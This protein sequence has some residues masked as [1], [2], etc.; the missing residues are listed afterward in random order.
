[1][2]CII[3]HRRR[4]GFTVVELLMILAIIATIGSLIA[5]VVYREE[6]EEFGQRIETWFNNSFGFPSYWILIPAIAFYIIFR[7][8]KDS[9]TR[10]SIKG[11]IICLTSYALSL[12]IMEI[13]DLEI[14][15]DEWIFE[16]FALSGT[17]GAI[18][19]LII[20]EISGRKLIAKP[21]ASSALSFLVLSLFS[22]A[23]TSGYGFTLVLYHLPI[24]LIG[25]ATKLGK[26][27]Q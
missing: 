15:P 11:M 19:I 18:S 16:N 14:L 8:N 23:I 22:L 26:S 21:F 25:A 6:L 27:K 5:R 2:R 12:F 1:M 13:S 24:I 17:L 7:V 10:A 3:Q 9:K 4:N 20:N